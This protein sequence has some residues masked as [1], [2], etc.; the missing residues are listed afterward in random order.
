MKDFQKELEA[1]E[2]KM[3]IQEAKQKIKVKSAIK[4]LN[5]KKE[6]EPMKENEQPAMQQMPTPWDEKLWKVPT[7]KRIL[8]YFAT[9]YQAIFSLPPSHAVMGVPKEDGPMKG[10]GIIFCRFASKEDIANITETV[11]MN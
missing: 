2:S 5:Q 6:A 3:A 4:K 9:A 11:E 10:Q 1:A 7:G 8:M